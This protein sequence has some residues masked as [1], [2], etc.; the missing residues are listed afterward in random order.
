V[1]AGTGRGWRQRWRK[2]AETA[3]AREAELRADNSRLRDIVLR[4]AAHAADA[5]ATA[6]AVERPAAAA[7]V[8]GM[9]PAH[10]RLSL[11]VGRSRAHST[12]LAPR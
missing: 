12:T 1:W 5:A 10:G 7:S 2:E 6:A 8:T 9:S 4:R 3:R 11:P